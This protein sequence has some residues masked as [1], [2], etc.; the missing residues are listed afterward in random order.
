MC[1]L[2]IKIS[3]CND[4]VCVRVCEGVHLLFSFHEECSPLH[5]QEAVEVL[6]LCLRVRIFQELM[7][8]PT[9]HRNH[10][11]CETDIKHYNIKYMYNIFVRTYI[12]DKID[13]INSLLSK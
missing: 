11:L 7:K 3:A 12:H 6:F 8:M 10:P 4:N 9:C 5:P 1:V 13:K 2:N